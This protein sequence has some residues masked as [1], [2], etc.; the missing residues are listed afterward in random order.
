MKKIIFLSF[1]IFFVLVLPAFQQINAT[2]PIGNFLELKGGYLKSQL[3]SSNNPNAFSFESWIKPDQTSGIQKIISIGG[4]DSLHYEISINGASLSVRYNSDNNTQVLITAGNL[5]ANIW[6][7]IAVKLA[8]DYTELLINGSRVFMI[9]INNLLLTVGNTIVVG[10]SYLENNPNIN[11][12]KGSIDEIRI[13]NKIRDV[14][15]LWNQGAYQSPLISD[16]Y[17][18]LLWHLD[19]N[20]GELKAFDSSA[21]KY[22]ATLVGND[23]LIHFF[24]ILPTPTPVIFSLPQLRFNRIILPT[25]ALP[26]PIITSFIPPQSAPSP[27]INPSPMITLSVRSSRPLISR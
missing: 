6:N 4:T 2:N 10:N 7:H 15:Q 1:L 25:L 17:T 18:V 9:V 8:P 26:R 27:G 19:E 3:S 23:S 12:F 5:Q 24:G 21:N 11:A 20:R 16:A 14:S 22:D 13:S